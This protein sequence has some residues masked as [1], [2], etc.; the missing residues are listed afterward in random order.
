MKKKTLS[1]AIILLGFLTI[2]A[3]ESE[4]KSWSAV[5]YG[6]TINKKW[7]LDLSQHLRLK[8]D[9]AVVDNYITQTEVYYKPAKRW[10]IS[11]QM[12]YYY[13]NDNKGG[14]QGFENMF[15]YRLGLEKKFKLKPGNFELRGAYQNRSSLDRENRTKKA[16][17]FRP[18]FEWKIKN[19]S[20]D[21]KFYF[22]YIREVG[23]DEQKSYR[24][25][26]GSKIKF[27]KTQG[28]SV[29]YFYQ[30]ATYAQKQ[31]AFSHV[32]SLKYVFKKAKKE[33]KKK[34]E[35]K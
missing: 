24:Y 8:E 25:G 9:L 26:V 27:S 34:E 22:E 5:E 16:W 1:L 10:K 3:Q 4:I 14:I 19:W 20:Y 30:K 11:A 7:S 23:G 6:F 35:K 31:D 29:R 28:L 32:L 21:P 13:R 15:R 12:R 17:R 33:G 18:L 2:N